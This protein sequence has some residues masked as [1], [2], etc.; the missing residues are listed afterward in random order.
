MERAQDPMASLDVNSNQC[1]GYVITALAIQ[2]VERNSCVG[3]VPLQNTDM[4][5]VYNI[6]S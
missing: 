6:T 4:H 1:I 2:Q 5:W 3:K